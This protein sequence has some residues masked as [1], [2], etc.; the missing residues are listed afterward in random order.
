MTVGECLCTLQTLYK[1]ALHVLK[2]SELQGVLC[3]RHFCFSSSILCEYFV[4][5]WFLEHPQTS[6]SSYAVNGRAYLKKNGVNL[7]EEKLYTPQ[8]VHL[9]DISALL[10]AFLEHRNIRDIDVITGSL[11]T[12]KFDN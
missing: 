5:N 9:D 6:Y 3:E 4:A 8:S 10:S 7:R 11:V 1:A 2:A 12:S